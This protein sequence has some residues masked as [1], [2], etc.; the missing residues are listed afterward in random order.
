MERS[1]RNEVFST[2]LDYCTLAEN[3]RMPPRLAST[4]NSRC[5]WRSA[6]RDVNKT[7]LRRFRQ[8]RSLQPIILDSR[9]N[10]VLSQHWGGYVS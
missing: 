2:R 7:L 10:S 8:I 6:L 1:K 4:H 3:H 9:A 5:A